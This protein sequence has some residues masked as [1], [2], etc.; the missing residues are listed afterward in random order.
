MAHRSAPAKLAGMSSY[1]RS[2]A[3]TVAAPA[4]DAI[5]VR[6]AGTDIRTILLATD[7]GPASDAALDRAIGLAGRLGAELLVVSV[8][9]ARTLRLPGGH[10]SARVDQVRDDRERSAAGIVARG[11][12]AGVRVRFLVWEGEAGEA[13]VEAAHAEGADMIVVGTHGRG[14]IGRFLLGSVSEYVVR[15]APVPVLVVRPAPTTPAA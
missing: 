13:I 3:L 10:F 1:H 7:L 5:S 6:P 2:P 15:H 8:I 12:A 4:S 11:R 14:G 9:D